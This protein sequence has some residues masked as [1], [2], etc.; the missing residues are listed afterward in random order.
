M[1]RVC[2][3]GSGLRLLIK[4]GSDHKKT[5]I[6]SNLRGDETMEEGKPQKLISQLC[7]FQTAIINQFRNVVSRE[8]STQKQQQ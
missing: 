5:V 8:Q 7:S 4:D 2:A 3:C 6:W 1:V